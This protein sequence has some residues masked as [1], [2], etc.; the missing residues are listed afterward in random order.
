MTLIPFDAMRHFFD[1]QVMPVLNKLAPYGQFGP[2]IEVRQT[3]DELMLTA[4][5][6]GIENPENLK[7]HV[8]ENSITLSG[9]VEREERREEGHNLFHT[10]RFYGSFTRT[11]PLPI[12]VD[13]EAVQATYRNG[14]LTVT[15]KKNTRLQGT[16]VR[17][18]FV[19]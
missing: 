16:P 7:I 5:I 3:P 6:P 19:Q 11:V 14:L 12:S 2:R 8:Q 18:D 10:E 17:V 1:D 13:P 4:E 15:M 9:K